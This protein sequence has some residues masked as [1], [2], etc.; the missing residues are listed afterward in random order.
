MTTQQALVSNLTRD[1]FKE[2]LAEPK[3]ESGAPIPLFDRLIDHT[4]D[5]ETEVPCKRYYNKFELIQ[6]IERE[7]FRILNTRS[8][9]KHAEFDDLTTLPENRGLVQLFGLADFS[10]YDGT[11]SGHRPRI[12]RLCEVAIGIFEPRLTNVKVTILEFNKQEQTL[13]A[14]ISALIAIPEY[15]QEITFPMT[16]SA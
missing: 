3:R 5:E 11:N 4:P 15:Q 8:N 7:V 6:S 1:I 16:I 14:A 13:N 2:A 10:Q 12:A 9:A